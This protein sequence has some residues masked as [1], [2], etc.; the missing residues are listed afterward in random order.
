MSSSPGRWGICIYRATCVRQYTVFLV[1]GKVF[2]ASL[3]EFTF[4]P[5]PRPLL[6]T[7]Y[8][9]APLG[10]GDRHVLQDTMP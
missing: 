3:V 5:L 4:L 8:W 9:H 6:L 10:A 7:S 1:V 2:D